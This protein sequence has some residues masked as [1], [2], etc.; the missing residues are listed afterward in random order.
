MRTVR[1]TLCWLTALAAVGGT[2]RLGTLC[3]RQYRRDDA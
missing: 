2:F 1:H 3:H